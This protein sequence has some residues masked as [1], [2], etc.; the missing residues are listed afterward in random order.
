MS[1]MS[2]V[3]ITPSCSGMGCD[4]SR[5]EQIANLSQ[6]GLLLERMDLCQNRQ[7]LCYRM[8]MRSPPYPQSQK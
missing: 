4:S 8:H 2:R 5:A 1:C 7:M 3:F 6:C